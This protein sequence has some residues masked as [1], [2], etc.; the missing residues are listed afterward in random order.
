MLPGA[1]DGG[2][3]GDAATAL[4]GEGGHFTFLNV[5]AGSY[6]IDASRTMAEFQVSN[7][8]GASSS[9]GRTPGFVSTGGGFF[10]LTTVEGLRMNYRSGNGDAGYWVRQKVSVEGRDVSD[11][12]VTMRKG[13]TISGRALWEGQRSSMAPSAN[14]ELLDAQPAHGTAALGVVR[15]QS[16]KA[17]PDQFRIE[18]LLPGEYVLRVLFDRVKSIVCG[19]RDYTYVPFDMS[20]GAD[21]SDC[22]VTFTDKNI[23]IDGTVRDG[24]GQGVGD[25]A[26]TVF[27]VEREQWGVYGFGPARMK[28][29]QVTTAGRFRF[30]SLPEGDYYFIAVPGDLIDAWKNPDFLEVAATQATRVHLAWGDKVTQD[31]T[32]KMIKWDVRGPL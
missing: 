20:S 22:V 26:V 2:D 12:V 19:G 14:M 24:S 28:S 5:A 27:P 23:M 32:V 13:A 17:T 11:V 30:Q 4:V 9:L 7:V 31:L 10:G 16:D 6:V 8:I 15:S 18:G 1:V 21:I 3:G 29:L 25:A